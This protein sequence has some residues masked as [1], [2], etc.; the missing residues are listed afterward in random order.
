MKRSILKLAFLT[1]ILAAE[2]FWVPGARATEVCQF[3]GVQAL[4]QDN[5]KTSI[6]CTQGL[7]PITIQAPCNL[8]STC[9]VI[10]GLLFC[11]YQTP[12]GEVCLQ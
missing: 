2:V 5:V 1:L 8:G 11:C 9:R 12:L 4:C 3:T 7:E 6:I 10:G